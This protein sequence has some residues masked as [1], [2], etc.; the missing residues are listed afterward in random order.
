MDVEPA[1]G[2][3]GYRVQFVI[4]DERGEHADAAQQKRDVRC[5]SKMTVPRRRPVHRIRKDMDMRMDMDMPQGTRIQSRPIRQHQ[6][7][8]FPRA[9]NPRPRLQLTDASSL[10]HLPGIKQAEWAKVS[11]VI[12]AAAPLGMP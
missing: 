3:R 9:S 7:A 6:N 4:D 8:A 10:S 5:A 2:F 11:S 12:R 1:Q